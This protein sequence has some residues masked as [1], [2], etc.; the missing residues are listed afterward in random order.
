MKMIR[1]LVDGLLVRLLEVDLR[2]ELRVRHR[3][4]LHDVHAAELRVAR[5]LS[6]RIAEVLRDNELPSNSKALRSD[7]RS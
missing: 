6:E 2:D 3:A 4:V 5:D 1:E 7:L